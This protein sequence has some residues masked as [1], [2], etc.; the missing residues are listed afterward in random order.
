MVTLG[1]N[2]M[3]RGNHLHPWLSVAVPQSTPSCNMLW[4]GLRQLGRSAD[5]VAHA[6]LTLSLT[7]KNLNNV[8]YVSTFTS[9]QNVDFQVSAAATWPSIT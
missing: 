1:E 6:Y 8:D 7:K 9:L 4:I 5:G 3:Q 2:L